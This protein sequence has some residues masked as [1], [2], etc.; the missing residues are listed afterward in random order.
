MVTDKFQV[1]PNNYAFSVY[2]LGIW[3][4]K[5]LPTTNPT[6][7]FGDQPEATPKKLAGY[8]KAKNINS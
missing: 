2:C 3:S 1:A 7:T 6:F 5:I 4:V 8:T